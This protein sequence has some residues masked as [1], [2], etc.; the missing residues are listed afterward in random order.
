MFVVPDEIAV[1]SPVVAF[2]VATAVLDELHTIL[3]VAVV[4]SVVV[5]FTHKLESPVI[6][7]VT[8]NA[9]TVTTKFEAIDSQ[10]FISVTV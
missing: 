7:G 2:I 3:P 10:L 1:T 9:F 4:D 6:A 8:G 5:S